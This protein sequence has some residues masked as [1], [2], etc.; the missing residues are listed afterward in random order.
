MTRL[1]TLNEAADQLRVSVR[2][3][4]RLIAARQLR[5]VHVGRRTL[6]AEREVEAYVAA[7][8]RRTA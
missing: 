8:Y 6:I 3:V 4:Q 5:P 7:A 2:T 1:L